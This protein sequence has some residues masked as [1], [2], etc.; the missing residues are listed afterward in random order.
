MEKLLLI[1]PIL[2]FQCCIRFSWMRDFNKIRLI[3]YFWGGIENGQG[4]HFQKFLHNEYYYGN[5]TNFIIAMDLSFTLHHFLFD[6]HTPYHGTLHQRKLGYFW[7]ELK[8]FVSRW[9]FPNWVNSIITNCEIAVCGNTYSWL[10]VFR[11][12][13]CLM[14]RKVAISR[15]LI[16]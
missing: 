2:S 4:L 6:T 16:F 9:K 3:Y 15:H 13:A 10:Q 7:Y 1:L 5:H 14:W 11:L 8:N 12:W